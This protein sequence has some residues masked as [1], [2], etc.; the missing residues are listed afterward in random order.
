MYSLKPRMWTDRALSRP[1]IIL[2]HRTPSYLFLLL[3]MTGVIYSERCLQVPDYLNTTH[4]R[5]I[6]WSHFFPPHF[7]MSDRSY[8]LI[9]EW[10]DTS[11]TW[12]VHERRHLRIKHFFTRYIM[13][14][15]CAP[16]PIRRRIQ[17]FPGT[18]TYSYTLYLSIKQKWKEV[19]FRLS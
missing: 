2:K 9:I 10:D 5:I 13:R 1:V 16:A 15:P 4:F 3:L 17:H 8:V 19:N 14:F 6:T 12:R 11:W 18:C 7:V